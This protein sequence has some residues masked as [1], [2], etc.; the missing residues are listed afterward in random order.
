MA[1][2]AV[3]GLLSGFPPT[4]TESTISA[5]GVRLC[6]FTYRSDATIKNAAPSCIKH[7]FPAVSIAPSGKSGGSLSK[8]RS[9]M[10]SLIPASAVAPCTPTRYGSSTPASLAC[11]ARECERNTHLFNSCLVICTSSATR[12]APRNSRSYASASSSAPARRSSAK[13]SSPRRPPTC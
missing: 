13:R 6:S 4:V 12:S 10:R 9:L 1:S 11:F 5:S 2:I 7:V 8:N 3:S